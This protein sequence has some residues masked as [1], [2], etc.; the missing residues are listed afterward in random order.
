MRLLSNIIKSKYV[1]LNDDE[2]KCIDTN[3]KSER[4]RII[5][6]EHYKNRNNNAD[7]LAVTKEG[8]LESSMDNSLDTSFIEGLSATVIEKKEAYSEDYTK[9]MYNEIIAKANEE[10]AIILQNTKIDAEKNM[11]VLYEEAS[12]RGYKD[13]MEKSKQDI[14]V[15]KVELEKLEA[16]LLKDYEEQM[17]ELEPKFAELVTV[18]V[19]KLTNI[20]VSEEN[21]VIRYLIHNAM[22]SAEP[23]KQF[24]IR[25]S[26]EDYEAVIAIKE[27]I[28]CLVNSETIV[29]FMKDNDLTKNQCMIETDTSVINCSLDVKLNGLIRD[30]KLLSSKNV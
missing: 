4:F 10:A 1:Y 3:E 24:I 13:G 15:Q 8:T 18:Y 29:E 9:E 26:R 19:E 12:N 23:S 17:L 2:K 11:K 25:I 21:E 7:E 22:I 20:C 5:H 28:E 30:I 27:E 16:N 14:L 6:L